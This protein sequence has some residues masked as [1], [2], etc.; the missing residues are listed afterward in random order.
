MNRSSRFVLVLMAAAAIA[1]AGSHAVAA[2]LKIKTQAAEA[3]EIGKPTGHPLAFLAAS[4]VG[5]YGILW[6]QVAGELQTQIK[7]WGIAGGNQRRRTA[8]A[9]K[10]FSRPASSSSDGVTE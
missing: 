6:D 9:P 8:S 1:A 4:S 3:F 7:T 2:W 10:S 5:G